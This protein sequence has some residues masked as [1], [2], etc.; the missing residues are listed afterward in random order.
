MRL[1]FTKPLHGAWP[2]LSPDGMQ[3]NKHK[4]RNSQ[5]A[6]VAESGGAAVICGILERPQGGSYFLVTSSR[7]PRGKRLCALTQKSLEGYNP[8]AAFHRI[9]EQEP[10]RSKDLLV[11]L[12]DVAGN[13]LENL[14]KQGSRG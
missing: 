2:V 12:L 14:Q 3:C 5:V 4:A 6:P 10:S 11:L 1:Y 9:R 13:L 8:H 7:G